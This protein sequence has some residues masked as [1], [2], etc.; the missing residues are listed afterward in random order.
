METWVVTGNDPW[1]LKRMFDYN[2]V[3]A[4]DGSRRDRVPT[5]LHADLDAF[6]ASVEQRDEPRLAGRPV[7]VGGGMVLAVSY[8]ARRFGV[9]APL[10]EREA[11]RRCPHLV[12]VKP[13]MEAYTEASRAVFEVFR[14]VSPM[15]EA[16]SIDE[17]FIDVTGLWRLVG[18]AEQV[19]ADLRRRVR[20]E[21]GLPLSVGVASTKFLAKV[22]SAVSKPDG[23]LVVEPGRELDFLHPLP[24]EALW[25][26]GP[27]TSE[28]LHLRGLRTVADVAVL[29]V[30]QL[31]N[32][33][34]KGAG[35]HLHALAN[36]RDPRSVEVG[37]RNRSIGSQRSFPDG[38]RSRNEVEAML[39]EITDRV[40]ARLRASHQVARTV[41]LRLRYGDFHSA[42][43]STTLSQASSSTAE[44][45][46]A[47][48]G[49]LSSTWPVIA[50]RGLTKVGLALSNLS[51][52]DAVQLALPLDG[53][54]RSRLDAAVDQ[55]RDRFGYRALARAR[56]V[57]DGSD[58]HPWH[59]TPGGRS[60]L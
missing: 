48:A 17:A 38:R 2:G 27:K 56:L 10:N 22:A 49:L 43:R 21:V 23:L 15:V 45:Q 59:Q 31:V 52:D 54:D 25:G 39:L 34:G 40:A 6:Y 51:P 7:A 12:V 53:H 58:P 11:R 30:D 33:V 60:H 32:L 9:T 57:G 8:E 28:R 42:T 29:P 41:T 20:D 47:G 36:N 4:N 55:A 35:R 18:P 5:I 1:P 50:D 24:V 3:M 14:D 16:M 26:V 37:R 19:A 13:R 44:F 46:R